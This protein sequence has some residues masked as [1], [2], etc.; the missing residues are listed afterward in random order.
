MTGDFKK[1][2]DG[3]YRI[4]RKSGKG[5]EYYT[6]GVCEQCNIKFYQ[7]KHKSNRFCSIKCS[8]ISKKNN[9]ELI[10]TENDLSIITG[11]LL[12]DGYLKKIVNDQNS[13]F[14]H[15]CKFEEYV[16]LLREEL[17]FKTSKFHGITKKGH[18]YFY[19]NS[20]A[21]NVFTNLR[22]KWY[23][24]NKKSI[25]KDIE[26]NETVLL[27]WFLGDGTLNNQEGVLFCTDCFSKE[28]NIFLIEKL[29]FY[30]FEAYFKKDKNRIVIPNKKVFE[31]LNFIGIS[32]VECYNHKWDTVVKESYFGRICGFCGKTFDTEYNHKKYCSDNC[33][34][35]QWRINKNKK[36]DLAHVFT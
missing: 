8:N 11:S 21:N 17:S 23:P 1:T 16:S 25:P 26:I 36:E 34:K 27:H 10:I 9:E 7:R 14:T 5:Y 2:K 29:N 6:Q 19:I 15:T 13:Y 20:Q 28:D 18:K 31:F 33:Q 30:N 3:S 12:S 4:L 32:P 24:N 35:K 22:K